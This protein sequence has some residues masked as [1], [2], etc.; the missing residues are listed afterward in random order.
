MNGQIIAFNTQN[1]QFQIKIKTEKIGWG[2]RCIAMYDDVHIFGGEFNSKHLVYRIKED[3]IKILNDTT[4]TANIWN[5]SIVKYK[6]QIIR[7]GGVNWD[8][9]QSVDALFISSRIKRNTLND[10]EWS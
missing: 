9:K 8:T 2:A 4:T 6:D 5:A 10:I 7:F 1:K 3:K